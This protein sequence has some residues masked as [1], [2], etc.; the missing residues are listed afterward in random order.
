[1][2]DFLLEI[3]RKLN[4]Q[5]IEAQSAKLLSRLVGYD[6]SNPPGH[7]SDA[8]R[9]IFETLYAEEIFVNLAPSEGRKQNVIAQVDGSGQL[10][11]LLLI[12]PIDVVTADSSR[13]TEF[14]PFSGYDDGT[15]IWGRGSVAAKSLVVAHMMCLI[16]INR[17][18]IPLKRTI[19]MAAASDCFSDGKQG[20]SYLAEN[21]LTQIEA[22]IALAWG[23]PASAMLNGKVVYFLTRAERDSL[24]LHLKAETGGM[25]NELDAGKSILNGIKAISDEFAH[26]FG[27]DEDT[28][29]I[30]RNLREISADAGTKDEL[31]AI[32]SHPSANSETE[33]AGPGNI[34]PQ[35][36]DYLGSLTHSTVTLTHLSA[37]SPGGIS[38]RHAEAELVIRPLPGDECRMAGIRAVNALNKLGG[39]GPY[40]AAATHSPGSASEPNE[41]LRRILHAACGSVSPDAELIYGACPHNQNLGILRE[42]G[43]DVY[44]FHPVDFKGEPDADTARAFGDNERIPKSSLGRLTRIIFEAIVR[45]AS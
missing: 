11:P 19:R 29:N 3:A 17:A 44:G 1:V 34:S 22:E 20:I 18:G 41:E 38:S 28:K 43:I 13:W 21:H 8:A 10:E 26:D 37:G 40:I 6:T 33:N 30:Y 2:A 16:L 15:H 24:V 7:T 31:D 35:V 23:F 5:D 32:F 12:G 36:A 9:F 14:N 4:W 27:V 39:N 25:I 42:L 45:M